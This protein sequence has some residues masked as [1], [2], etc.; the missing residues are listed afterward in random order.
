MLIKNT[1]IQFFVFKYRGII[2][3]KD[4]VRTQKSM[5]QN[6]KACASV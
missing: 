3:R 4:A 5:P 1:K 2:E 6:F